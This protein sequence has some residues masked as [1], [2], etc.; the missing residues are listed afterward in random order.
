M[1]MKGGKLTIRGGAGRRT[2]VVGFSYA[3]L[4]GGRGMGGG[5]SYGGTYPYM[6]S[7]SGLGRRNVL[8]AALG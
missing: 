6:A 1:N 5:E 3:D 2:T 4:L 7:S 8:G